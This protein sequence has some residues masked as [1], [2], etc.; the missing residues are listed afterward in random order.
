LVQ[1]QAD[2]KKFEDAGI[3]VVAVSY[4]SVDVLAKFAGEKKITFALLS[5]PD[6]KTIKAFD[7]LNKEAT[8]RAVGVP[9]P[10]TF[11][12]DAKGVVRNKIF[13]DGYRQRHTTDELIKAA[14]G[15]AE[16]KK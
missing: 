10:G 14:D 4:D 16:V 1:L 7:I 3:Q 13:L 12:I 6:S 8:G 2:L 5:D 11:I 9:Y 15:K